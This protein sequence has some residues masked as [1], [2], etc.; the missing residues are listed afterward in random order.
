MLAK[1]LEGSLAAQ[2]T[3]PGELVG[4]VSFMSPERTRGQGHVDG[5]SDLYSLGATVYAVLTGK[6]PFEGM[7]LVETLG[8][9]RQAEP[10]KPRHYQPAIPEAFEA[11]VLKMLAKQPADRP[12]TAADLL[13][14][15]ERLAK[16]NGVA[17]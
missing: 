11:L 9:I 17:V 10:K 5:R 2:I 16:M 8:K 6:P 15:L 7:S 12:Q 14:S 4:D 1:A 13:A 3:K